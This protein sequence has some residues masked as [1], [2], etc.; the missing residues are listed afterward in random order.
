[1]RWPRPS[2]SP[3]RRRSPR[4]AAALA[5]WAAISCSLPFLPAPT[6]RVGLEPLRDLTPVSWAVEQAD[7][8]S[9]HLLAVEIGRVT[10]GEFQAPLWYA[11]FRPFRP[12]RPRALILAGVRGND[13]GAVQAALDLL[14]DLAAAPGDYAA[15]DL[16]LLPLVNPWGF[17]HDRSE[18]AYGIDIDR[19]F[20][21]FRS[22]E[23]RLLR[24]FLREKRY[25]LVVELRE[26]PGARGFAIGLT[27]AQDRTPATRLIERMREAGFPVASDA[28]F[29]LGP[30]EGVAHTPLWGLKILG[31][32]RQGTLGGYLRERVSPGVFALVTPREAPL[33]ERVAMHRLAIAGLLGV[34]EGQP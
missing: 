9:P 15:W 27:G 17:V 4:L 30:R 25:D 12:D 7:A 1:M 31:W 24:K 23:A 16:D 29:F 2:S 5:A 10:A 22:P 33:E 13:R 20:S 3:P 19:D 34:A 11:A 6:L 8:A 21:Q 18:N 14:R 26:D 28:F 32:F